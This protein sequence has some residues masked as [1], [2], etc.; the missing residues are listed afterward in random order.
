MELAVTVSDPSTVK[1]DA[2]FSKSFIMISPLSAG[3]SAPHGN[4]QPGAEEGNVRIAFCGSWWRRRPAGG[5]ACRVIKKRGRDAG[6]TKTF[7][8]LRFTRETSSRSGVE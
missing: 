1:I 8:S 6:A 4:I 3:I 2:N 7:V 5:F